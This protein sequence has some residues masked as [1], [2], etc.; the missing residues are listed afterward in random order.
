MAQHRHKRDA[1]AR[2]TPSAIKVAG[3]LSVLATL[4]AV[5]VGVLTSTPVIPGTDDLLDDLD[6][7]ETFPV[8]ELGTPRGR[9]GSPRKRVVLPEGWLDDTDG[10][11]LH[12]RED[13]LEVTGG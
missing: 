3:P 5:A 10:R 13:A 1:N 7:T 9:Q 11:D 6:P 12:V 4:S 2:R 8:A